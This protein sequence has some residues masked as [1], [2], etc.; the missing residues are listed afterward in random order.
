MHDVIDA[1]IA[2]I[3]DDWDHVLTSDLDDFERL[4]AARRIDAT[5]VRM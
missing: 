1:H 3:V 4:L 5:L 2:L